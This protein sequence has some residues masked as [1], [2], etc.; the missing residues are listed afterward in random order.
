[1]FN[2]GIGRTDLPGGDGSALKESIGMISSLNTEYLLTGHGDVVIGADAV[3][4]NFK[5]IENYWFGYL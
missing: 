2:Q 1:M 3:K 5:M 4:A